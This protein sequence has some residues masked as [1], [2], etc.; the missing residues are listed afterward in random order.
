VLRSRR[1]S[2]ARRSPASTACP[3]AGRRRRPASSGPPGRGLR[4]AMTSA[5]EPQLRAT[6]M[7]ALAH[8]AESLY[9]P[10]ADPSPA[11]RRFAAPSCSPAPLDQSP[12]GANVA[13][14]ALGALLCA[15]ASTGPACPAPR[16]WTDLR[17]CLRDAARR[18]LRGAAP[19][20]IEAMRAV[21]PSRS[22]RW[23]PRSAPSPTT[24]PHDQAA[25]RR[26]S[27]RRA[28]RGPR[29]IDAVVRRDGT[30]RALPM[31]PGEV[32]RSDLVAILEAAW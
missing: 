18:D 24:F 17:P 29:C 11:M 32:E 4:D 9:T 22:P 14:L 8:G 3:R 15:I 1:R 5:P 31:T 21:L 20:T 7:N 26:S 16:P 6:A 2:P 23:R 13:A 27:P 19:E 12:R 10:L 25:R 30:A 28:R